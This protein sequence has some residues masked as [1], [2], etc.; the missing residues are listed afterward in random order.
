MF[1]TK[2]RYR[3]RAIITRGL[4]ILNPLFE[5]QKRFFQGFFRK[6]CPYVWLVFKS[7]LL[8]RAGYNGART[9][10]LLKDVEFSLF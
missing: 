10:Y 2:Y 8:S 5:G 1:A 4:Y 6:F 3:T 9:V 7:G